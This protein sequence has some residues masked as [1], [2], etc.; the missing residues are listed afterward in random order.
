MEGF[1]DSSH[2]LSTLLASVVIILA[3]HLFFKFAEFVWGIMNKKN[4]VSE[5]S[6]ER[7][8]LSLA[9]NTQALQGLQVQMKEIER[10]LSE[11]PKFKLDL[12]RAFSAVKL[13]SGDKWSE[14]RK[15][16]M[17]DEISS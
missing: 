5:Q 12:R 9:Q 1:L 7:L 16:I 17:E 4:E 8:S 3:L 6:I 15:I 10:D 2:G 11:M 13:V 14:I